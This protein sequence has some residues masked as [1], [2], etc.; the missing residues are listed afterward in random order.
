MS[1][2]KLMY[3]RAFVGPVVFL[4]PTALCLVSTYRHP[5]KVMTC[6]KYTQW[7]N[8]SSGKEVAEVFTAKFDTLTEITFA[9]IQE[10]GQF[11]CNDLNVTLVRKSDNELLY[12][13]EIPAKEI[14]TQIAHT[15]EFEEPIP[16][17]IGEEYKIIFDAEGPRDTKCVIA[18]GDEEA[19]M[20]DGSYAIINGRLSTC[21]LY[22]IFTYEG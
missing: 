5:P 14:A 20:W 11:L 12:Y 15:I 19:D 17:E 16:L 9:A 10:E 13:E 8:C 18:S 6:D 3:L 7:R 2:R 4:V 1:R 21:D 22:I